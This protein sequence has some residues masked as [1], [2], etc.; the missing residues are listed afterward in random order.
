MH[1][2]LLMLVS[3][4]PLNEESGWV[5]RYLVNYEGIQVD[6]SIGFYR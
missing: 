2:D 5:D 6:R 1:D 3:D 4:Y